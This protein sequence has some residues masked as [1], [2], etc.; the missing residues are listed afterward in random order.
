MSRWGLVVGALA[1]SVLALVLA[2]R[3]IEVRTDMLAFLPA[4]QTEAARL[5]LEE[6]RSGAATGLVLMGLEGAPAPELARVARAMAASLP[7]TGLFEMVAGGAGAVPTELFAYRYALADTA[8]DGAALRAGMEAVLRQMR[9]SAAPLAVQFG[10]RDPTGAFPALLR[11]W[12]PASAVRMVDGAWFAPDAGE[13]G[14]RALLLARTKAGGMDIPAQEAALAAIDRAFAE[15]GPGGARLLVSGPAVFARDAARSIKGDVERISVLSTVLVAALL[16]WRFRSP[17][18]LAAVATPV[19]L[20]VA[21]AA[22]VVQAAFG[23]VHGVALGFGVTMLG[24]SV[25]YPV[26][27]I[28]HRKRGEAAWATRARIGRAYCLAVLAA[29]L[30]LMAMV[31]SGM[32]GLVQLGVFAAVGLGASAVLTWVGLPWLVVRADLAPVAAGKAGWVG[33]VEGWRRHRWAAVALAAAALAYLV[34]HGARWEG[35]LQALS[36][37]PAGSLALDRAM[38]AQL[39]APDAGLV[40]LVRGATA[41]E[42]LVR[43]EA[44]MPALERLRAEGAL[45]G[46]ELAARLLPSAAVQRTRLAALPELAALEA[47]VEAARAGLPFRAGS[48]RRV[49]CGC[50]GGAGG[51][52]ASDR[53]PG[54][55][56]ARDADRAVAAASGRGLGGAGRAAGRGRQGAR[57]GSARRRVRCWWTY[58]RSWGACWRGR[59][60]GSGPGLVGRRWRCWQSWH[61]GCRG[62]GGGPG[63]AMPRG[64]WGRSR[65]RW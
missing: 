15:A 25:D 55:H 48:V 46:A 33:R 64:W 7:E 38:R 51:G 21:V 4:G 26:L 40:A 9:G 47:R 29:L 41:E 2:V 8:L 60:R 53:G 10:L 63:S 50:G 59:H 28:G 42:V 49:S 65:R 35:D 1:A 45:S 44:L 56:H 22:L 39:G 17:L 54:R 27:M 23:Q 3:S 6:A 11:G 52:A 14:D 62:R 32:P 24:V 20:G 13:G 5:V 43:Q 37:V 34:W 31:G 61:S 12:M 57:G 58:G 19:V 16:W 18:V 36:P 30:G